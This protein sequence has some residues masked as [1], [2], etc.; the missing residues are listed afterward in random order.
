MTKKTCRICGEEKE[1]EEFYK[2]SKMIGGRDSKCKKCQ[3]K[4]SQKTRANNLEYRREYGRVK[5]RVRNRS[6][7]HYKEVKNYREKYPDKYF[8]TRQV[9]KGIKNG[10]IKKDDFCNECGLETKKLQAHHDDYSLPLAIKWLCP[11]CH[12]NWH[13]NNQV[14]R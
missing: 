11:V 12:R 3:I 1:L 4:I 2:H 8:A 6:T 7:K 14:I 9:A 5:S 13:V 10:S